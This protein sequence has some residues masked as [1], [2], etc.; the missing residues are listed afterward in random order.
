MAATTSRRQIFWG[1]AGVIAGAAATTAWNV[2]EAQAAGVKELDMGLP[3]Y[4]DIKSPKASVETVK[5]LSVDTSKAGS[6]MGIS[7]SKKKRGGG[8][9]TK[10][11]EPKKEKTDAQGYIF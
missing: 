8:D 1:T 3:S 10:K 9:D 6:A 2:N 11:K 5:S 7:T 4:G